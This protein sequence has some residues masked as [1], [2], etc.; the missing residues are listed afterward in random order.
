LL[1]EAGSKGKIMGMVDCLGSLHNIRVRILNNMDGLSADDE[2]L[3]RRST[4]PEEPRKKD[5]VGSTSVFRF[6]SFDRPYDSV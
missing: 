6:A 3:A 4:K 5:T 1:Q 2:N